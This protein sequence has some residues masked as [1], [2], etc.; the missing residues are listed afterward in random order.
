MTIEQMI[1][2][3]SRFPHKSCCVAREGEVSGLE[4]RTPEGDRTLGYIPTSEPTVQDIDTSE[5]VF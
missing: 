5:V 1:E 4:I 2:A 3:L